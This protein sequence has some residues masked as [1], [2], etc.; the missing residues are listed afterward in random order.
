MGVLDRL[1]HRHEQFEPLPGVESPPDLPVGDDLDG[2]R[3]L[4][5]FGLLCHIG[6]THATFANL[7]DELVLPA[8]D[9][10]DMLAPVSAHQS[11]HILN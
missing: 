10:A 1:G 4:D 6:R 7:L 9:R 5:W 11:P 3:P 8:D 2:Y